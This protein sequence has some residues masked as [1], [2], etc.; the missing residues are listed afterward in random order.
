VECE[1]GVLGVGFG[2]LDMVEDRAGEEGGG[3]F[4]DW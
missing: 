2:G 4:R 3:K 1:G